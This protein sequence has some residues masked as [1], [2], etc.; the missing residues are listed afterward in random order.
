MVS[1]IK[2]LV[3][4]HFHGKPRLAPVLVGYDWT[5]GVITLVTQEDEH[6]G[7]E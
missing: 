7:D 4:C 3:A 6:H 5:N 2:V 1:N